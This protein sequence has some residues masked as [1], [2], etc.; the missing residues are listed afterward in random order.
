MARWNHEP[1]WYLKEKARMALRAI[2]RKYPDLR[3]EAI[4]EMQDKAVTE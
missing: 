3:D 4:E 1:E 2:L